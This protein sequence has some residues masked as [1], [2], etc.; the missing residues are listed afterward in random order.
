MA[1]PAAAED[2]SVP[3]LADDDLD[4]SEEEDEETDL[5]DEEEEDEDEQKPLHSPE[6]CHVAT[7]PPSISNSDVKIEE[8][9]KANGA[10]TPENG[11]FEDPGRKRQK[12]ESGI[13]IGGEL[14]VV[15][16]KPL[17]IEDSRRLFQRLFSDEDEIAILQGFLD[18]TVQ[19]STTTA[20][21]HHQ[22]T[23]PFYDQ[24]KTRLQ[25]D[26]NKNQLVEKL[27]RL[28]KKYRNV[29][30]KMSLGKDYVFKSAHDQATFEISRRIWGSGVYGRGGGEDED[31]DSPPSLPIGEDRNRS[32]MTSSDRKKLR[33]RVRRKGL[34][35]ATTPLLMSPDMPVEVKVGESRVP[36]AVAGLP[37][38]IEETVRSCISPL[39]KELLYSAVGGPIGHSQ[40]IPVSNP[41]IIPKS[42]AMEEKWRKQQILELEVYSKRIELVQDQIKMMLEDLRK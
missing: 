5:E 21:A 41:A 9:P 13:E 20:A 39:F 32:P 19:R 1:A 34:G 36:A 38:L 29:V 15:E 31:E 4:D 11:E 35:G 25:L 30:G 22:D 33:R 23:G 28:K 40:Q 2:R 6:V 24:I 37:G 14:I 42:A 16:K 26:F 12:V 8:N 27:R 7:T 10:V 18:F 3:L 17:V